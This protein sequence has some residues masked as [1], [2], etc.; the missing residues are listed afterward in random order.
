MKAR[1]LALAIV[2][3]LLNVPAL[4][5]SVQ[6]VYTFGGTVGLALGQP[7][8]G[9]GLVGATLSLTITAD[10]NASPLFVTD[11]TRAE[12]SILGAQLT[13]AGST[14]GVDGIYSVLGQDLFILFDDRVVSS[15]TVDGFILGGTLGN[16][17]Q[18]VTGS[19]IGFIGPSFPITTWNTNL[20]LPTDFGGGPQNF[21]FNVLTGGQIDRYRLSNLSGDVSVTTV[22]E[23][24][25]LAL[26]AAGLLAGAAFRK[27]LK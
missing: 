24:S 22:P 5:D 21:L 19:E 2:L 14:G 8:D 15:G 16:P 13:I 9:V 4:G 18:L 26:L 20:S 11:P 27:R 10:A 23:P 1:F 6:V 25:T 3:G 17:F 7:A 12:Y